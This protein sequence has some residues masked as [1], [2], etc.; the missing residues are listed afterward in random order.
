MSGD[1]G[2]PGGA[3]APRRFKAWCAVAVGVVGV[4][5][6]LIGVQR[7]RAHTEMDAILKE[8]K[9]TERRIERLKEE[10]EATKSEEQRLQRQL[11][12]DRDRADDAVKPKRS[13]PYF[14]VPGWRNDTGKPSGRRV[15]PLP[16]DPSQ[17][18]LEEPNPI[19]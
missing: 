10:F 13:P 19:P 1:E 15:R 12:Q 6:A 2:N 14:D 18:R 11:D 4:S 5:A 9:E 17:R 7:W 16:V 8:R 3:A